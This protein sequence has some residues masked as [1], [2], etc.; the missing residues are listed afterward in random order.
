MSET[1]G[2]IIKRLRKE[3]NFTQEELAEQLGVTC[4]AVSKWEND[5]GL[6]DIS[7]VVP[8]SVVFGVSTD[9]LFGRFNANDEATI[10]DIIKEAKVPLKTDNNNYSEVD[11]YNVLTDALKIYPN[12]TKLLLEA[13]SYGCSIL[14]DND[15]ETE[16]QKDRLYTECLHHAELVINYSKDVSSVLRVHKWLV[17]LYCHVGQ[18]EKAKEHASMFPKVNET[19]DMMQAWI[20]RAMKNNDDEIKYRC[21]TF[22]SLLSAIEFV[23]RPLGDAYKRQKKYEEAIKVYQ[24]II[25][26]VE[27]VYGDHEY[28]PPMHCLAWV[29]FG[30]AHTSLLMGNNEAAIDWLE[31]E[32]EFNVKNARHFNKQTHL[33]LP[34]LAACEFK[35]FSD[36]YHLEDLK[37]EFNYSCFQELKGNP[38]FDAL[39]EKVAKL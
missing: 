39:L 14:M 34:A 19:Q 9:V 5:S 4:Q 27:A 6:P 35:F 30:L 17:Y 23:L 16:E 21:N 3:R 10:D 32:F 7:Q 38:R 8:L 20:S 25:N 24:T 13:L 31:K 29:H 12:N 2:Q 1:M 37:E 11:C 15:V 22:A 36:H 33:P 26:I 18:F 28:T